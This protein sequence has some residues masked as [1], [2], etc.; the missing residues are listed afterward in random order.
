MT[1]PRPRKSLESFGDAIPRAVPPSLM[2]QRASLEK[3][4]TRST[5]CPVMEFA[6]FKVN[7]FLR[8]ADT[9]TTIVVEEEDPAALAN[10]ALLVAKAL[11]KPRR[12]PS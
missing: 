2:R 4:I 7:C 8:A 10:P 3:V 11:A 1:I 9:T 12:E 6:A 5:F